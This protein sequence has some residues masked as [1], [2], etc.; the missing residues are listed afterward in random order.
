MSTSPPKSNVAVKFLS[1]ISNSLLWLMRSVT[2]KGTLGSTLVINWNIP[3]IPA[4]HGSLNGIVSGLDW[5]IARRKYLE[6][7]LFITCWIEEMAPADSPKTVIL[8]GSPLKLAIFSL[9]HLIALCWSRNP[10]FPVLDWSL[11]M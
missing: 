9:T 10:Q 8:S 7:S 5:I 11:S 3:C 2:G 1:L 4:S 6:L